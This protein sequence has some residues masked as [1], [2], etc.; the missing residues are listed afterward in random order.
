MVNINKLVVR[1]WSIFLIAVF[2]AV[3]VLGI[4]TMIFVKTFS[5]IG[6]GIL[7]F[8]LI[9]LI[10]AITGLIGSG[11]QNEERNK[12]TGSKIKQFLL[13]TFV[14]TMLILHILFVLFG[15]TMIC[16]RPSVKMIVIFSV[17]DFDHIYNA[18]PAGFRNTVKG[19][20]E[21]IQNFALGVG[22]VMIFISLVIFVTCIAAGC[23]MGKVLFIKFF[24]LTFS[25]IEV[26]VGLTIGIFLIIINSI[27]K[28]IIFGNQ[29][30]VDKTVIIP[31]AVFGF[32][33]AIVGVIGFFTFCL[34]KKYKFV[35]A[36]FLI[37][38]L[39]VLIAFV[40][41]FVLSIVFRSFVDDWK[42]TLCPTPDDTTVENVCD[43][44]V[45]HAVNT[46]CPGI[47]EPDQCYNIPDFI[48]DMT[49][50]V[51]N[52]TTILWFVC[53]YIA[54]F[55]GFVVIITF[56]NCCTAEQKKNEDVVEVMIDRKSVV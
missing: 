27:Q 44:I 20:I 43:G 25:I 16:I 41:L 36:V 18:L 7:I 4:L 12:K 19:A 11:F 42:N 53:L 32:I 6:I 49:E 31:I 28:N 2:L 22:I 50:M 45:T 33:L 37:G 48:D 21:K 55:L 15:V 40:V 10:V 1:I 30:P 29:F 54:L 3:S 5:N 34:G 35:S 8:G 46:M 47:P 14:A 38:N 9:G 51:H 24:I 26:I 17:D 39:V 23:L 52:F 13:I 56:I